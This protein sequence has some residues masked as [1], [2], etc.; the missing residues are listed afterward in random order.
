MSVGPDLGIDNCQIGRY[1][2]AQKKDSTEH[3]F[4]IGQEVVILRIMLIL[5]TFGLTRC[6]YG[7]LL[8]S[9]T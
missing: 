8:M 6:L 1:L 3:A 9:D 7:T 4:S 2:Q 5:W